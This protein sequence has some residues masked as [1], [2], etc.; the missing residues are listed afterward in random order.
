MTSTSSLTTNDPGLG[1]AALFRGE[2]SRIYRETDQLFAR[3]LLLEWATLVVVPLVVAL[4]S[5]SAQIISLDL[6]LW[7][8]LLL[9]GLI[10]LIPVALTRLRPGTAVTRYTIDE[11]ATPGERLAPRLPAQIAFRGWVTAAREQAC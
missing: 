5:W 10:T 2:R 7:L 9:A 3:L 6:H 4:E 11:R 8:A 1:L